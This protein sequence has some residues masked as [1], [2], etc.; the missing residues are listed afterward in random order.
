MSRNNPADASTAPSGS[1]R[2]ASG[3][4]DSRTA[5]SVSPAVARPSGTLTQKIADQSNSSMSTPPR[6]GPSPNPSPAAAAQMP[7][8]AV[9]RS[10]SG[11]ASTRIDS[12]S[13][14]MSA[15]PAPCS[16]RN[17]TSCGSS[18][19]SAHSAEPTVKTRQPDTNTR[20][21]P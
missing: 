13:G 19:A 1:R 7:I 8:A 12:A 4:R 9:R 15:A 10:S 21:R 16:A 11:N 17:A 18:V 2:R 20:L 5:A 6:I 14:A 3:L